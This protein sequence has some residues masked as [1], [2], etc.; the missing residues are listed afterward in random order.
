MCRAACAAATRQPT[1]QPTQGSPSNGGTV[2]A[3]SY[4]TEY[5]GYSDGRVP[6]FGAKISEVAPDVVGLQECQNANALAAAAPGY[7]VLGG[8]GPQNY[9]L[10]DGSRLE[11]LES[12]WMDVPRDPGSNLTFH[13]ATMARGIHVTHRLRPAGAT[14]TPSAR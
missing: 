13:F 10:Y 7:T 2:V 12:G 11:A 9:I 14:A 5:T 1:R 3:M 6:G 4:N 8:T